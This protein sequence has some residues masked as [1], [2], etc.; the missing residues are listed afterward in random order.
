MTIGNMSHP[1]CGVEV[2][3]IST[4]EGDS[5]KISMLVVRGKPLGF[6]LLFRIDANKALGSTVVGLTGSV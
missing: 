4:D 2:V 3:T 1:C 6:G 5:G